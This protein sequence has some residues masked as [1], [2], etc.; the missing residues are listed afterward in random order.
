MELTATSGW[1][2]LVRKGW[3]GAIAL[4]LS[5]GQSGVGAQTQPT[6]YT[7][8]IIDISKDQYWKVVVDRESGQYLGHVT[9]TLQPDG[10]TALFTTFGSI[11]S[12]GR[13]ANRWN[14]VR[15]RRVVLQMYRYRPYHP[16]CG[17]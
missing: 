7:V 11:G 9:T 10:N 1:S 3:G 2:R 13:C 4:L 5:G 12:K 6:S 17:Q 14:I 15:L 8:P 16:A